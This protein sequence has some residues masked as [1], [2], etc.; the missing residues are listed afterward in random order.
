MWY[1]CFHRQR[2]CL[3]LCEKQMNVAS[4]VLVGNICSSDVGTW[5]T[6]GNWRMH[7]ICLSFSSE[8]PS[9]ILVRAPRVFSVFIAHLLLEW[10]LQFEN[11]F[12]TPPR[13]TAV[14]SSASKGSSNEDAGI[15]IVGCFFNLHNRTATLWRRTCFVFLFSVGSRGRG[16]CSAQESLVLV[17]VYVLWAGFYACR[18]DTWGCLSVQVFF[19]S[20]KPNELLQLYWQFKELSRGDKLD[21]LSVWVI[22][23][24]LTKPA[25]K[26]K[27]TLDYFWL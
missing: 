4:F 18:C 26:T 22:L 11:N 27:H 2:G 20:G 17:L 12:I 15:Q 1:I 23:T 10:P 19:T 6:Q 9:Q 5:L 13:R 25:L 8:A 3:K 24:Y 7:K 21:N 16:A 14:Y